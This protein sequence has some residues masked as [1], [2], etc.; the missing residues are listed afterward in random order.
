M[1]AMKPPRLR[2]L[3]ADVVA[4]DARLRTILKGDELHFART[5]EEA[6]QALEA[7]RFDLGVVCLLFDESRMFELLEHI[8]SSA[9][10]RQLP[11]ACI[12]GD[13][14]PCAP[15][16]LD[17]YAG[18]KRGARRRAGCAPRGPS[19]LGHRGGV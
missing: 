12:R 8:G 2:I 4:L 7:E 15:P 16:Q 3:I 1:H 5:R 14:V 13:G 6:A 18:R 11:V 17:R 10:L 19:A 9:R